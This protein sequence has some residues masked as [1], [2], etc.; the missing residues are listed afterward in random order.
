M[1]ASKSSKAG[2]KRLIVACDGTW[3]NSDLGIEP[4]SYLPWNHEVKLQNASN[5]TRICRALI[6]DGTT[7]GSPQIIRYGA[8]VGSRTSGLTH[9]IS[10]AFGV[11]LSEDIREAY[12]FIATNYVPGDEIFLLGWSRGAFTARSVAALIDCIGL[13]TKEG[14]VDFYPIFLDWENQVTPGFKSQWPDRP[15]SNRPNVTDPSYAATLEGMKLTRLHVR[16]KAMGIWDTVG[17]YF[18]C[19][20]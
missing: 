9:I 12:E 4:V 14:M 10:G 1:V 2:G 18:T 15:Y 8:G 6:S 19:H 3:E 7:E 20:I 13:L 5:V 11:G 16:V 17:Q